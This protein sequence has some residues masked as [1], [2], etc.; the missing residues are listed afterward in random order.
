MERIVIDHMILRRIHDHLLG[1]YPEEGCGI[2]LGVDSDR[3]GRRVRGAVAVENAWPGA[4]ENRYDI[5]PERFLEVEKQARE[6]GLEVVGFYHSH[7]DGSVEPSRFDQ[8][9]AWP[10]YSYMIVAV[11]DG[12]V[13]ETT[14][15]VRS[16]DGTC[17]EPQEVWESE[18][19]VSPVPETWKPG[20]QDRS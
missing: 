8:E 4:R 16:D 1:T 13:G 17:L 9:R 20:G 19:F 3:G 10:H 14:S 2:L 5:P 12:G 6:S 18:T 7:P 15:W 11:K